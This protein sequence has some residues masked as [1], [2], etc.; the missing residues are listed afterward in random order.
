MA[1]AHISHGLYRLSVNLFNDTLFEG[2]WPLPQGCSMNSY[3]VKGYDVAMVD[4]VWGMDPAAPAALYRQLQGM[5][6]DVGDIRYVVINHA[7][8]DHTGWLKS[9]LEMTERVEIVATE[10]GVEIA[11]SFYGADANYRVVHT[12]DTI[13]LGKGKILRFV[14]TPNVHWPETMVTYEEF[15]GAVLSCDLFGSFGALG[16][17]MCDDQM[18]GEQLGGYEDEALRYYSNVL[19]HFSPSVA[20][21]IETVKELDPAIIAPAHGPIWRGNPQRIM[22]LYRRFTSFVDGPAEPVVTVIWG[23]MYGNTEKAIDPIVRGVT[24]EGVEAVVHRVPQTHVSHILA[25][26]WRSTGIILAMPTYEFKMFPPMAAVLEDLG[27]K[28]VINKLAFRVGS[29]GWSGG[30]QRELEEIVERQKMKWQFLEPVE[31]RGDA[32]V[33]TL[34]LLKERAAHLARAVKERAVCRAAHPYSSPSLDGRGSGG[35]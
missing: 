12:G 3:V 25:S 10:K 9:L 24:S 6:S 20:R 30:A 2:M 13:D 16:M 11:R 22:E 5:G 4:G 31:F 19:A 32:G 29:F 17:A 34:D 7:E 15:T 27:R 28:Q 14:E 23:S 21:A 26:A 8:P 33:E 18:S 35:G 1:A